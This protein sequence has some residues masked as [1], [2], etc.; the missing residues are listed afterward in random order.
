M[1]L[2]IRSKGLIASQFILI[3]TTP[4]TVMDAIIECVL[5]AQTSDR[6]LPANVLGRNNGFNFIKKYIVFG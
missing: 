4:G 2:S 5:E 6:A 1:A 3:D